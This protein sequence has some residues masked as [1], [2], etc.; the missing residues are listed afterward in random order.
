MY[1]NV[2]KYMYTYKHI[3]CVCAIHAHM[4]VKG[5]I[6]GVNQFSACSMEVPDY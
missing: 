6:A 4:E 1:I 2:H 5:Q 3:L